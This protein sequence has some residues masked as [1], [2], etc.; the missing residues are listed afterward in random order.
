MTLKRAKVIPIYKSGDKTSINE[1]YRPISVLS[2]F[3][4]IFEKI[5]YNHLV[6]FI[7][8]NITF[9][10]NINLVLGKVIQQIMPLSLL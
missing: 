8:I 6:N 7:I 2:V 10:I 9:H 3:S 1:N 5:M 4:K